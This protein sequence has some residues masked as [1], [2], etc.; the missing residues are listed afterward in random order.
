MSLSNT[1]AITFHFP[2]VH[3][4]LF[5]NT[6]KPSTR[7]YLNYQLVHNYLHQQQVASNVKVCVRTLESRWSSG[8]EASIF[9]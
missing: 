2:Y 8:G 9:V 3:Y 5:C 6:N 7:D 4:I 1:V